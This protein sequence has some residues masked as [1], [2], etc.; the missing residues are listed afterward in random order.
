MPR[1]GNRKPVSV[2]VWKCTTVPVK[3]IPRLITGKKVYQ[4]IPPR[5]QNPR[6]L[7]ASLDGISSITFLIKDGARG[8]RTPCAHS[9]MS[10]VL[11]MIMHVFSPGFGNMPP[12]RPRSAVPAARLIKKIALIM[13]Q[14]ST[15]ILT[16]INNEAEDMIRTERAHTLSIRLPIHGHWLTTSPSVLFGTST[17]LV[18]YIWAVY[19]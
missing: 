8:N 10:T 1:K 14:T 4:P 13:R 18:Y 5:Y 6:N 15:L 19:V 16:L 11:F 17:F 2:P 12:D 7:F 9:H 3:R